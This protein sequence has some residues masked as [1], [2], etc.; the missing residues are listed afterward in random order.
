[1]TKIRDV[2]PEIFQRPYA[3]VEPSTKTQ[4]AL[5]LLAFHEVDALPVGFTSATGK[6]FVVSGY[7]CLSKLLQTNPSKYGKF[8]DQPSEE[9]CVELATVS[10][11]RDI[12]ALL[13]IFEETRFGFAWVE[14][15][16]RSNMGALASLRDLL[17][18]FGR[19]IMSTDMAVEDV[20]TY[21]VFSLS[22]D[23]SLKQALEKMIE[24]KIRRVL[25]TGT[26]KMISDR[27]IIDYVFRIAR[28]DEAGR[29]PSGLLDANLDDLV[30]I[31]P[32]RISSKIGI[33][34][35]AALLYAKGGRG[36]CLVCDKG[37]VTPWDMIMKPWRQ[38]KLSILGSKNGINSTTIGQR[39]TSGQDA[40]ITNSGVDLIEF[41]VSRFFPEG[42]RES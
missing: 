14:N 19:S 32:Q 17:P 4:V 5:C 24:K 28:L 21:P 42:G 23:T 8:L 41:L 29:K 6:K 30:S 16:G 26:Q 2:L 22:E 34:K 11:D 25:I 37:V 36:G 3:V 9:I 15:A 20:A 40:L 35:A 18:L 1:M 39:I 31:R 10:A 7:S 38:K 27:Q 12:E 33:N 13:K